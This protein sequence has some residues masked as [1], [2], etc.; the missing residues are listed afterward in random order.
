MGADTVYIGGGTPSLLTPSQIGRV[1]EAVGKGF[2]LD[3]AAEISMEANPETVNP[4]SLVGYR[5]AGVNRISF[6]VQS[7]DDGMLK[8]LGRIHTAARAREAAEEARQAGFVNI[9]ADMLF[10]L[11]SQTAGGWRRDLT[12]VLELPLA[13]LSCYELAVESGTPLAESRPVLP[14]EDAVLDMW[15]AAE[16]E[17]ARA[18]FVHYEVANYAL[19][20]RECRHN[21]KYWKDTEFYGFGTSAWSYVGGVRYGNPRGLEEY[22]AGAET[23]FSPAETDELPASKRLAEA[24]MM[25]LRLR[26]GCRLADLESRYG[27]APAVI[28]ALEPHVAA[29]RVEKADGL[30]RLTRD[31][32]LLANEVWADILAAV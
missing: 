3:P 9:G 32:L 8:S 2:I 4:Q 20:G 19:P 15:N 30:L 31:G 7:L 23:G 5:H 28:R 18:G 22:Y 16:E 17:T 27:P 24:L 21:L 25:G 10:G 12:K 13:H 29:G 14:G 1:L 11:P 26:S 6:G